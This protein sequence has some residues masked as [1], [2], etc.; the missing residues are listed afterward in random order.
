MDSTAVATAVKMWAAMH[1][2]YINFENIDESSYCITLSVSAQKHQFQIFC[3]QD[4]WKP[5][6]SN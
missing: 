1:K 2:D 6:V 4:S 3:Q 5:M